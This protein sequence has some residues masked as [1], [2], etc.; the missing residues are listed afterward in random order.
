M[1]LSFS[2]PYTGMLLPLS[3]SP[4]HTPRINVSALTLVVVL[5]LAWPPCVIGWLT[6]GNHPATSDTYLTGLDLPRTFGIEVSL[7]N[8]VIS[9]GTFY[10]VRT[11]S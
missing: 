4:R 11:V 1:S 2:S 10:F 7:I 3:L 8:Q 5:A 6:T 9:A